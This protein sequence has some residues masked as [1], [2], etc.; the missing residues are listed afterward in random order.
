MRDTAPASA[1]ASTSRQAWLDMF[2]RGYFRAAVSARVEEL[3][4][5]R[6]LT[7]TTNQG[8]RTTQVNVD[9]DG[10]RL[11]QIVQDGRPLT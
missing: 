11:S 8:P 1:S 2:A 6:V 3:A 9:I 7:V 4:G 5:D 10:D